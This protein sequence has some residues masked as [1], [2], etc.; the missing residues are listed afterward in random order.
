MLAYLFYVSIKR[1]FPPLTCMHFVYV[2]AINLSSASFIFLICPLPFELIRGVSQCSETCNISHSSLYHAIC[3]FFHDLGS[4]KF[5]S[6]LDWP[7]FNQFSKCYLLGI[8]FEVIYGRSENLTGYFL[9]N[10]MDKFPLSTNLYYWFIMLPLLY[11]KFLPIL[12]LHGNLLYSIY[13]TIDCS[14][15]VLWF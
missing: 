15:I 14:I 5:L 1:F 2:I 6:I 9:A 4:K 13:L 3:I 10:Y 7:I 11:I 12:H 8:Y